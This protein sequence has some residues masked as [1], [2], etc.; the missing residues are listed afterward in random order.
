M[1]EIRIEASNDALGSLQDQLFL[2]GAAAISLV[3]TKD[4]PIYEPKPDEII[5]WD[6]TTL[7]ALFEDDA[8]EMPLTAYFSKQRDEGVITN[9]AILSVENKDWVRESLDQFT[10]MS[11]GKRLWIVPSWQQ[12]PKP[13]AVNILLDPGLA[14]GTGSHPTTRL[15]L[16]WLDEHIHGGE[17]V[18]DYG[19][20]SGILAIAALKLGAAKVDG[21]DYD[22]QALTA[23]RSNALLNHITDDKLPLFLPDAFP[24]K[25]AD[26]LIA[27]ILAQPIIEF[28]SFF[29]TLVKPNGKIVLSG[30]LQEQAHDVMQAYE[31]YFSLSPVT[32]HDGWVRI[33]GVKR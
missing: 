5:L 33:D 14:F 23:T 12:A 18:I 8:L 22:Q 4:Q 9:F 7:I 10:P 17:T 13:K 32:Q 24:K 11:F 27:N 3:D 20:G 1:F 19:C 29:T 16:E 15:C 25:A 2:L 6:H 31:P 28:A 21:V 30:I 26:I